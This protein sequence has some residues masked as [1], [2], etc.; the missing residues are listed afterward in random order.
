M[1]N[2]VLFATKQLGI[3]HKLLQLIIVFSQNNMYKKLKRQ[4]KLGS[5]W[6]SGIFHCWK[7]KQLYD[8][9]VS[10]KFWSFH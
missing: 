8:Y 10:I 5:R 1:Q 9:F 4:L 3:R 7:Y 6:F 2:I